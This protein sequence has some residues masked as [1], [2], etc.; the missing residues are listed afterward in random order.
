M[1]NVSWIEAQ[2]YQ[3]HFPNTKTG[4][5]A[6]KYYD[7]LAKYK[8]GFTEAKMICFCTSEINM[9]ESKWFFHMLMEM[10]NCSAEDAELILEGC[11]WGIPGHY[12]T[13]Y[14]D[15]E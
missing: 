15:I 12:T 4:K 7:I 14:H 5:F 13:Y 1:S 11:H 6:Q 10:Y 3:R 8:V 9:S 2:F